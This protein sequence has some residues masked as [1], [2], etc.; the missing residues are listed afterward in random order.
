LCGVDA[1]CDHGG[2]VDG[3]CP[4]GQACDQ[5]TGL[6]LVDPTCDHGGAGH[7][8]CPAG[9]ACDSASGLCEVDSTCAHGGA[10]AGRCQ[11]D[12]ECVAS[13]GLCVSIYDL[14][15][16]GDGVTEN[17]GDCDDGSAEVYPTAPER[18]GDNL[19]NDCVDG[20]RFCTTPSGTAC[21][22][23][24]CVALHE[25]SRADADASQAGSDDASPP[26]FVAGV[27]PWTNI[28]WGEAQQACGLLG[29]R[30]CSVGEWQKACAGGDLGAP[31]AF[32][33]GADYLPGACNT[34]SF[35]VAAS[36][37]YASCASPEGVFDLNGNVAELVGA[38]AATAATTG[39]DYTAGVLASCAL[40]T[41]VEATLGDPAVGFRCCVAPDDDYDA[42]GWNAASDCDDTDPAVNPDAV[43][44]CN[45]IDDDCDGDV[46]DG[47]DG[48]GD[49]WPDCYDCNDNVA[50]IHPCQD[51]VPGDGI[52]RDC[53]GADD[54][55][56]SMHT[57]ARPCFA[58]CSELARA[59][60]VAEDGVN[61]LDP[62]GDGGGAP[63][64]AYCHDMAHEPADY[65]QLEH[66]GG[67]SNYAVYYH[68][69]WAG[70]WIASCDWDRVRI[71]D[72][73]TLS[74]D[75]ADKTFAT[76]NGA[77]ANLDGLSWGAAASCRC[78]ECPDGFMN[79]DLSGTP[80][81][82]ALDAGVDWM[83]FGNG[84]TGA[85]TRSEQGGVIVEAVGGGFCGGFSPVVPPGLRLSFVP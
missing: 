5:A 33:Y 15:H 76:C 59:Q 35:G 2:A 36:G 6:C 49:G 9:Q 42:D 40:V 48:D 7:G 83:P 31:R 13:I 72:L 45:S 14:D 57:A 81:R 29:M 23:G 85:V 10:T 78:F 61:W 68:D 70:T 44:L 38:D 77:P 66:T 21:L 17:A 18:C 26:R 69:T 46:D 62:D 37:A 1:S 79:I 3:V 82:V 32:S 75:G 53:D 51:D 20:D 50:A 80:L 22:D 8:I 52:D 27:K 84:A 71:T 39:G 64:R 56:T 54:T 60:A 41:A 25:S 74:I 55:A 24:I 34:E 73:Q 65:L 43:E 19:D 12:F 28:T 47:F 16:D 67:G 63:F 4:S 11:T 58:S 30:L